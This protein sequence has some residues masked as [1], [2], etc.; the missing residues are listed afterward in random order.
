MIR[1]FCH[2]PGF[3]GLSGSLRAALFSLAAA[4]VIFFPAPSLAS[5]SGPLP[6]DVQKCVTALLA[7][8][9]PD[10]PLPDKALLDAFL[11]YTTS[12]VNHGGVGEKIPAPEKWEKAPGIFWRSRLRAPLA[13]TLEYL[14]NP[15]I[16]SEIVYPASVRYARWQPGSGILELSTPLWQQFGMHKDAPLVLRGTELEEITPD[17]NSGAYY[18]Y[19]LDRVLIMTEHEGRQ[20][21]I[22]LSW[23]NGR[24]DVGKKAAVIGE[25]PDWDYVYSNVKGTLAKGIGWAETYIYASASIS[26]FYEDAPGGPTTGY[27][28][29]RWMN[30]G[31]SGMNMVKD[32]H[33]KTGAERSFQGLKAFLESPNRPSASVI[34]AHAVS[35][36]KMGI[37]SL[38]ARF[39]PYCVKVEEAASSVEALRTEDFQRVIR[40]AGYGA[41]L[42]KN[43]IIA[44]MN[45]NFIKLMLGKPLLAGA[46]DGNAAGD[47]A[48]KGLAAK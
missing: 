2:K 8:Q 43:E 29:Y 45:V 31:W 22:S 12:P 3:A 44:A 38:R 41:S 28:M 21:L 17:P 23:Q 7:M 5:D 16:P 48:G 36:E 1:M 32:H 27:A 10:A 11:S 20:M 25:Y 15:A 40:D 13:T 30:A 14:Y 19:L 34:T 4:A 33:I 37:E 39:K 35:L 9:N 47:A 18:K 42:A 24:S 26:V 6:G 46:L